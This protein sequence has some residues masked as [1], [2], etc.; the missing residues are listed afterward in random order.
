MRTLSSIGIMV[1]LLTA[2]A[3]SPPRAASQSAPTYTFAAVNNMNHLPEFVGVEKGIFLKHGIDL[4]LKVLK[5]GAE[6][7]RAFQAGEAQFETVSPTIMVAAYNNGVKLTAIA[8]IMGDATIVNYDETFAVTARDG[9]GI[10]PGHIEDLAGKRVG[11]LLAGNPEIYLRAVLA[12]NRIPIDKV[13]LVNVP[14]PETASVMRSGSIDAAVTWEPYGTIVLDQVPKAYLVQR[15]GGYVGYALWVGTSP[16]FLKANSDVAQRLVD[17]FAEA[18]WYIRH[19]RKEAAIVATHWIEG[20]DATSAEKAIAYMRFDPRF[21]RST[22]KAA[23]AEQQIDLDQGRI[24][25]TIDFNGYLL[26]TYLAKSEKDS[27]RFFSDLKP[28]N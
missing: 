22:I 26:S 21:S 9:S 2:L 7:M 11:T 15:G 12:K 13:T 1:A 10:R 19:N 27:P 25:Q 5:S 20:L 23:E 28:A 16:E 24:K 6:A 8:S 18:S 4:K 17:G 3:V 14:A